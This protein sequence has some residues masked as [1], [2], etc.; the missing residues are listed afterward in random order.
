[1]L[2]IMSAVSQ[3]EREAI[4][5]LIRDAMNHKRANA[6]RVAT[7]R[8]GHRL[9]TDRKHVVPGPAEQAVLDQIRDLRQGGQTLQGI[10][11][12]LKRQTF[13]NAPGICL[14]TVVSGES[15]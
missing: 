2:N 10:A 4:G 5:E 1:V 7:I 9:G 13:R 11:P 12:A 6:E 15:R 14:A 8:F 3:W